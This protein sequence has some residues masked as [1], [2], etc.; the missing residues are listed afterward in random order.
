MTLS[1]D[2]NYILYLALKL[3]LIFTILVVVTL[4]KQIPTK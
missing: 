1:Q 2:V 4:K 3:M